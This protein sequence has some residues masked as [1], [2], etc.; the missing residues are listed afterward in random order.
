[1]NG[2]VDGMYMILDRMTGF[3]RMNRMNVFF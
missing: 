3:F 1:M 2:I